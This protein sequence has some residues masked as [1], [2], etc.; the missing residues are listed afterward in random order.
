M[1]FMVTWRTH[2]DK[3]QAVFNAFS[4][5][6]AEDDKRDMGDKIRLIGRWHDLSQF[7]GV[8]I[9]ECDDALAI[10]SWAL[11]WNNVLDLQTVVVL[12]DEEARAVGKNKLAAA[13]QVTPASI[14]N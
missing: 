3:R 5:M 2:A 10:A 7:S 12:D 14:A 13:A 1:K 11:N 4:Q 8:A 9:C 6:T